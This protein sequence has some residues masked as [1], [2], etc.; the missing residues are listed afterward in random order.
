MKESVYVLVVLLKDL[1]SGRG[2]VMP[3]MVSVSEKLM[4]TYIIRREG[5][6][7]QEPANAGS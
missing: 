5:H 1:W 3:G 2:R 4:T 6:E 7:L